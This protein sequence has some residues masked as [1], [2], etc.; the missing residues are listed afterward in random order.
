MTEITEAV[1]E[2]TEDVAFATDRERDFDRF[3]VAHVHLILSELTRLQEAAEPFL[4]LAQQTITPVDGERP[5]HAES[6]DWMV[7][8][9]FAGQSVTLG[10]LRKAAPLATLQGQQS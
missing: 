6:S 5:W 4:R 7:V 2:L 8:F 3:R 1:K 10:D 9:S